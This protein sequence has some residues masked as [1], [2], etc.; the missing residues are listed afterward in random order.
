MGKNQDPGWTFR[1]RNTG[2]NDDAVLTNNAQLCLFQPETDL[3]ETMINTWDVKYRTVD[4]NSA[5]VLPPPLY[6]VHLGLQGGVE[7]EL[8]VEHVYVCD[9]PQQEP[10]RKKN[11]K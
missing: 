10:A 11:C 5:D 4:G 1:I 3:K 7:R 2:D 8:Q 9:A 6:P